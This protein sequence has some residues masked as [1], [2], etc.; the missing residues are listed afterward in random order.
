MRQVD[1][2]GLGGKAFVG[3]LEGIPHPGC[4]APG[5]EHDQYRSDCSGPS[6]FSPTPLGGPDI[7]PSLTILPCLASFIEFCG[8][9]E[10]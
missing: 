1:K 4:D 8:P 7:W 9:D 5:A 6:Q 3:A 10:S 2:H